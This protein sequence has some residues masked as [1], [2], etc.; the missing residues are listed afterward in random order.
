MMY[1]AYYKPR[2]KFFHGRDEVKLG[3]VITKESKPKKLYLGIEL[4]VE[5][6]GVQT[7]TVAKCIEDV[8]SKW[9]Y[10]K[11]DGSL[12]RG[13][14][15]VTHPVTYDWIVEHRNDISTKLNTIKSYGGR[16]WEPGTAG[17]HVHMSKS[18]F[19]KKQLWNF[20]RLI[21]YYPDFIRKLSGKTWQAIDDWSDMT[22]EDKLD[23][24]LKAKTK[25]NPQR[26]RDK[27]YGW[28]VENGWEYQR[29]SHPDKYIAVN[30]MN[31]HTVEVRIFRSSLN[32]STFLR[33][34]EFCVAAHEY[35]GPR[36]IVTLNG[37]ISFVTKNNVKY[38]NLF[39]F[40]NKVSL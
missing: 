13:V 22:I 33:A 21:Y 38:P 40:I 31:K 17:I 11:H 29:P 19:T 16:G 2:P 18:S 25:S 26:L 37:L 36:Q 34:I 20:Q 8:S 14:E 5:F 15:F 4:E 9:W 24:E 32:P 1:S 6:N 3:T 39:R 12:K 27:C 7:K 30:L 23:L 28:Y 10:P 35:S